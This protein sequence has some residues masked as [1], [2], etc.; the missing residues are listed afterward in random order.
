MIS[1]D[2]VQS[3]KGLMAKEENPINL[4][5]SGRLQLEGDMAFGLSL[6][7]LIV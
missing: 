1:V 3:F 6:Q 7:N 4:F 5:M 2:W